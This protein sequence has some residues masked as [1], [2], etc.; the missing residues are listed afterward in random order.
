VALSEARRALALAEK[1]SPVLATVTPAVRGETSGE[2]V[3]QV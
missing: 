2:V 1:N 3:G